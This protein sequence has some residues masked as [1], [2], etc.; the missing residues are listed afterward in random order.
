VAGDDDALEAYLDHLFW[1]GAGVFEA[2]Q[3]IWGYAFC[4]DVSIN[5]RDFPCTLRA[6]K[7]WQ[8]CS[9][10]MSV[11]PATWLSLLLTADWLLRSRDP[12]LCADGRIVA[13]AA[14]FQF[15]TFCRPSAVLDAV[16][17]CFTPP[18]IG[19][20]SLW[21]FTPHPRPTH[22]PEGVE[23][24]GRPLPKPSKTGIFDDAVHLGEEAST[25][26]GRGGLV[27][28]VAHWYT[29]SLPGEKLFPV[30]LS[31]YNA[32]LQIAAEAL[33]LHSCVNAHA[34]RHGGA[35][36]D[37]FHGFRSLSTIKKRGFWADARSVERYS[38]SGIYAGQVA[39]LTTQHVGLA[40]RL[41]ANIFDRLCQ[42]P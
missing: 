20:S 7:G 8:K 5:M 25:R 10:S 14:L 4:H 15:D 28:A 34:I 33:Q 36:H 1:D 42:Y 21:T 37:S 31:R 17:E 2:R 32:I 39:T 29:H 9:P 12:A 16:R 19:V 18:T 41:E 26:A 38:K 11:L 23:G 35:S 22:H 27:S 6:L 40:L 30:S 13:R 3:S 24:C